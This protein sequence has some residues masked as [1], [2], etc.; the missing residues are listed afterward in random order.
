M[1]RQAGVT[2]LCG[3]FFFATTAG[4]NPLVASTEKAYQ[5][6][7]E[8]TAQLKEAQQAVRASSAAP[9][10]PALAAAEAQVR[11]AFAQCCHALH[12]AYLQAAKQAL[13]RHNRPQALHHLLKAEETLERCAAHAPLADPHDDQEETG[14]ASAF[15]QR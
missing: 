11:R 9:A 13:A 7:Q 10:T 3:L 2:G 5:L 4:A 12:T 8:L 14:S 15:A 6:L 1:K